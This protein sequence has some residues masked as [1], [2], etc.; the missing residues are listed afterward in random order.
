[1]VKTTG[2]DARDAGDVFATGVPKG[3]LSAD[4]L[5]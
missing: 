1:M 4:G 3:E 2:I 5:N